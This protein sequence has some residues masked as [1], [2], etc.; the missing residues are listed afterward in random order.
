MQVRPAL[1]LRRS[2]RPSVHPHVPHRR[3]AHRR[4]CGRMARPRKTHRRPPP[5]I[6]PAPWA[7]QRRLR[8]LLERGVPGR[9]TGTYSNIIETLG[10]YAFESLPSSRTRFY[11][12]EI[13]SK[14]KT[15]LEFGI[16]I[17]ILYLNLKPILIFIELETLNNSLFLQKF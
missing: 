14:N 10:Y 2:R 1:A 4:L 15:L 16:V 7:C 9:S 11:H 12:N 3:L 13:K 6:Q 8:K 17:L 5:S